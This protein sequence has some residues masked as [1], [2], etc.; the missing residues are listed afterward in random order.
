MSDTLTNDTIG[1]TLAMERAFS[2]A[3]EFVSQLTPQHWGAQ[4]RH[5]EVRADAGTYCVPCDQWRV[6]PLLACPDCGAAWC[7]MQS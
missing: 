2:D 4:A 1:G 3:H 5:G 6:T 7:A